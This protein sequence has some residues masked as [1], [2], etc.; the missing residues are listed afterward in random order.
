MQHIAETS[1]WCNKI[2]FVILCKFAG[3]VLEKRFFTFIVAVFVSV[4]ECTQ[5]CD[6][7]PYT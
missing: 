1:M 2:Y 7:I 6:E 4:H 3:V 5:N